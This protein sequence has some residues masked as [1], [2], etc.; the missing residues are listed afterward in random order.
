MLADAHELHL[1]GDAL[2][3]Q[4]NPASELEIDLGGLKF[5]I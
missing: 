4:S 2:G 5:K 1:R 3:P